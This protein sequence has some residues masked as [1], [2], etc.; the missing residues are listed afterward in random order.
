MRKIFSLKPGAAVALAAAAVCLP[1]LALPFVFDDVM[2]VSANPWLRD[3]GSFRHLFGPAYTFV[4]RNEGFEPLTFIPIMLFGKVFAW[5]P[6]GLHLLSLLG[7]AACSW[8][9]YRLALELFGKERPA[10]LAGLFFAL[11]PAQGETTVAVL[12][13]GTI[14]SALF[15]L[16]ALRRFIALDGRGG[17][18][19]KA[20]TALLLLASLLFKERAFPGV[21]LFAL[22]PFLKKGGGGAEF[23]RRLPEL[24]ACGAATAAALLARLGSGRGTAFSAADLDPA[25]LF[26]KLA[27]YAKMTALPF[28][29][30][31]VYQRTAA[32][33]DA[34]GL[35]A[36][37]LAAGALLL[38]WPAERG[39]RGYS[40]VPA[41]AAL[42]GLML[43]PYL[44]LLPLADLAEYLKS[45]FV[46]GRY[47]YLPLAG[48]ALIFGAAAERLEAGRW[49]Y[50]APALLIVLAGVSLHQRLLWRSDTA[51]WARAV[52]LNPDSAWGNYMLGTGLLDGGETAAA[53]PFLERAAALPSNRGVLSNSLGALAAAAMT[54]GRPAEAE[55]LARRALQTWNE[56]Y[57]AWN[58]LGAAL[59]SQRRFEEAERAFTTAASSPVTA[60]AALANRGLVK[61]ALSEKYESETRRGK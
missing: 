29:L 4:F 33:G 1:L 27:A 12:F 19:G 61:K 5:L 3:M 41:G 34:A 7:H 18:A 8:A 56:N 43:L 31:P 24:L 9:V 42:A 39:E 26:A 23:R 13:S 59:A 40:P 37:A 55:R 54:Q 22:L 51:V 28:W 21:L 20:L 15:F 14:F 47:L 50:A 45:V 17:A 10:L 38:A 11:H 2:S 44:N 48:A 35:A 58:T 52:R 32:W 25:F 49:R 53:L 57:D 16:L 6:W 46:S 36:L 30:S 60:E